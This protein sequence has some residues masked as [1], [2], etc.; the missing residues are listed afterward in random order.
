MAQGASPVGICRHNT[1]C[2]RQYRQ[3]Q[4]KKEITKNQQ[5]QQ[6]CSKMCFG[7]VSGQQKSVLAGLMAWYATNDH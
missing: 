4:K 3:N 7:V 2:A 5:N 6:K 1:R